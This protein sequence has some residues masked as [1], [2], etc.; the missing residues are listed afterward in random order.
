MVQC[1]RLSHLLIG[2]FES[3][4]YLYHIILYTLHALTLLVGCQEEHPVYKK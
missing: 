3:I 1:S 2:Y 4:K